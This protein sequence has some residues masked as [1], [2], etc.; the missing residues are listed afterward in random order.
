MV[1]IAALVM[2]GCTETGTVDRGDELIVAFVSPGNCRM[3]GSRTSSSCGFKSSDGGDRRIIV[4]YNYLPPSNPEARGILAM[5]EADAR[6]SVRAIVTDIDA[7]R[8]AEMPAGYS[9]S[10]YEVLPMS[11]TPAG[12]LA[13][14]KSRDVLPAAGARGDRAELHCWGITENR[15]EFAQLFL[16]YIEYHPPGTA[17]LPSFAR[18]AD[19]FLSSVQVVSAP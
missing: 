7:K 8:R 13:C 11:R 5:S 14:S 1:L 16:S 17:V 6:Q 10:S 3:T 15:E 9:Q 19:A 18:D 12:L 2:S 4:N